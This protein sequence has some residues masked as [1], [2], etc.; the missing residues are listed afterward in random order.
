MPLLKFA[1]IRARMQHESEYSTGSTSQLSSLPPTEESFSAGS[2]NSI[3][4]FVYPEVDTFA[5]DENESYDPYL[6]P[7]M[8]ERRIRLT[9]RLKRLPSLKKNSLVKDDDEQHPVTPDTTEY[10]AISDSTTSM[11]VTKVQA[12]K[13][14]RFSFHPPSFLEIPAKASTVNNRDDV[15]FVDIDDEEEEPKALS[16]VREREYWNKIANARLDSYSIVHVR[17]AE[18]LLQLGNAHMRCQVR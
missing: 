13:A 18:T 17:T 14:R 6:K 7:L 1:A 15:T 5:D 12:P 8:K 2:I 9:N 3:D 10:E 11:K 16:A 4:S